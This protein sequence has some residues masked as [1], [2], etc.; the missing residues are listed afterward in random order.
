MPQIGTSKTPS[1]LPDGPARR[2][3]RRA[4]SSDRRLQLLDDHGGQIVRLHSAA[5]KAYHSTIGR[6][7][8]LRG[9]QVPI[10]MDQGPKPIHAE[11]LAVF[12]GPLEKTVRKQ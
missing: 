10:V 7:D 6:V 11:L 8:N 12:A 1:R 4:P 5:H 9:G 2:S 3:N